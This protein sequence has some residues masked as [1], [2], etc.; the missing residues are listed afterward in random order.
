[1]ELSIKH[2]ILLRARWEITIIHVK[3]YYKTQYIIGTQPQLL[4]SEQ[5]E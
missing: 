2:L 4:M 1:M 3:D 5:K